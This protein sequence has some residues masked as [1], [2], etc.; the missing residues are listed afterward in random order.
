MGKIL[1]IF[2]DSSSWFI[3]LPVFNQVVAMWYPVLCVRDFNTLCLQFS[4][5]VNRLWWLMRNGITFWVLQG[6]HAWVVPSLVKG[7]NHTV[8][9]N[10]PGTWSKSVT[11][12][13][14]PYHSQLSDSP[15]KVTS[16]WINIH[17]SYLSFPFVHHGRKQSGSL[18]GWSPAVFRCI[19][20]T[21]QD[22]IPR[23]SF[24]A[25]SQC[26]N[27]R[28]YHRPLGTFCNSSITNC[29]WLLL[30]SFDIRSTF[31]HRKGFLIA[32]SNTDIKSQFKY[33]MYNY[34]MF[35]I[36]FLN[37]L[38]LFSTVKPR[39]WDHDCA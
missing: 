13:S 37:E 28:Y 19:K 33:K 20:R 32:D 11:R 6:I 10:R 24:Q 2:S 35:T 1:V 18:Q 3:F 23:Y 27:V 38:H 7:K 31:F 4:F 26:L 21:E 30:V 25:T 9:D 36:R 34:R 16:L 5:R 17:V 12:Y 14:S 15:A 22:P 8:P 29:H 39:Q